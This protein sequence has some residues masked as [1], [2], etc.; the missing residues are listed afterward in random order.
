M[1]PSVTYILI[2][3]QRNLPATIQSQFIKTNFYFLGR[4]ARAGR[5]G[6]AFSLI[7]ADDMAHLLDLQL[8]LGTELVYPTQG[9]PRGLACPSGVWG[10]VPTGLLEMRHQDIVAWDK[11]YSEIV[12][13]YIIRKLLLATFQVRV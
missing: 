8:F 3:A 12:S 11:N 2:K 4:S 9:T 13:L 10:S 6:R 1:H 7:A 5:A